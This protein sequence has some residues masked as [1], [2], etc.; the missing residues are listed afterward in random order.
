[1]IPFTNDEIY[2]TN[3]MHAFPN[4][5]GNESYFE[6]DYDPMFIFQSEHHYF[7][8]DPLEFLKCKRTH[9]VSLCNRRFSR[10]N[11]DDCL[12]NIIS[13]NK[14]IGCEFKE[15]SF[16]SLNSNPIVIELDSLSFI[17]MGGS[18]IRVSINCLDYTKSFFPPDVIVLP[19]TCSLLSDKIRIS[20]DP[21]VVNTDKLLKIPL[22]NGLIELNSYKIPNFTIMS[23]LK[24]L[25][26]INDSITSFHMTRRGTCL[27]A[28]TCEMCLGS[29]SNE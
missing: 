17:N 20:S 9:Q 8:M 10:V 28:P 15:Y 5:K 18:D 12:I 23:K 24:D 27:T 25:N 6:V 14:T 4:I 21:K 7:Y 13:Q 2:E 1:M 3:Y 16:A 26:T 29:L 11:N 19:H 22:L